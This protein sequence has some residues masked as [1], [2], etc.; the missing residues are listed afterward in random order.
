MDNN[1]KTTVFSGIILSIVF[2]RNSI[3][4]CSSG[5]KSPLHGSRN[6]SAPTSQAIAWNNGD[7][8]AHIRHHTLTF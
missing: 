6:G 2:K 7:M 5:D 1:L 8:D 3:K 4:I